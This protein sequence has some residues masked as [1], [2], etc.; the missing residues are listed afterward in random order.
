MHNAPNVKL[1]IVKATRTCFP[2]RE[3]EALQSRGIQCFP[4]GRGRLSA[5]EAPAQL[6]ARTR[7]RDLRWERHVDVVHH[8]R[9]QA[10][11][12]HVDEE[13]LPG[14]TPAATRAAPAS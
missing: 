1:S 9:A 2:A 7:L 6:G 4:P 8:V 11:L 14:P 12:A 3:P 13:S 5:I 10:R